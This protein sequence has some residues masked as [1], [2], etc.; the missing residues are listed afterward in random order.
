[1]SKMEYPEV[2]TLKTF[3]IK[4]RIADDGTIENYEECYNVYSRPYRF[5]IKVEKIGTP[6]EY[7]VAGKKGNWSEVWDEC[8]TWPEHDTG[9]DA[10]IQYIASIKW[11]IIL[12]DVGLYNITCEIKDND[13]QTASYSFIVKAYPNIEHFMSGF[14]TAFISSSIMYTVF[15]CFAKLNDISKAIIIGVSNFL[16]IYLFMRFA[17][18]IYRDLAL[19]NIIDFNNFW[20]YLLGL[21]Y[22]YLGIGL[23]IAIVSLFPQSSYQALLDFG[24]YILIDLFYLGILPTIIEILRVYLFN[25]HLGSILSAITLLTEIYIGFLN[26]KILGNTKNPIAVALK[27]VATVFFG[28]LL[29]VCGINIIFISNNWLN[30]LICC[31]DYY[32]SYEK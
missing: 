19:L 21:G 29:I 16:G 18:E 32:H 22:G 11:N 31:K 13:N 1:M 7:Y 26:N 10:S 17:F 4:Y 14:L 28:M 3:H 9:F 15:V 30:F 2:V 5:R 20:G 12:P 6:I 23:I 8:P 27:M 24:L 25:F